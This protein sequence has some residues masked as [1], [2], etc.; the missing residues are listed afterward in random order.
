LPVASRLAAI[1]RDEGLSLVETMVTVIVGSLVLAF[2]VQ[3]GIQA[4]R[5]VGSDVVR[6]DNAG[7]SRVAVDAMSRTIRA[8]VLP[9]LMPGLTCT[10]GCGTTAVSGA[11]I[12]TLSFYSDTNSSGQGPDKVTYDVVTAGGVTTLTETVQ[13]P[14]AG[15]AGTYSFCTPGPGCNVRTRTLVRG[16]VP[17]T[18]SHVLFTYYDSTGTTLSAPVAGSGTPGLKDIDSVDITLSVQSKTAWS[19]PPTTVSMRVGMPNAD[20]ARQGA[21]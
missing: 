4:T 2:T 1:H 7:Q 8:A 9:S 17:V 20:F 6:L 11:N 15:A 18:S 19:T 5:S 16:L 12:G 3:L 10:A 21:S 14:T 13:E